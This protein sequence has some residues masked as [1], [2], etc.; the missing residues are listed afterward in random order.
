M[1]EEIKTSEEL[2]KEIENGE[3]KKEQPTKNVV[4]EVKTMDTNESGVLV[5]RNVDEAYRYAGMILK[6]K[7]APLSFD[8]TEKILVAM[9]TAKELDLPPLTSLKS[10]YVIANVVHLFGDLPLALCRRSKLM[11]YIEEIQYDQDGNDLNDVSGECYKAVCKVK[12]IGEKEIV[13]SITWPEVVKAGLDKNKF[14]VKDTYAKFRRRMMQ[15][16]MRTWALKDAFGDVLNG[17]SIF[18]Y[19]AVS[20]DEKEIRQVDAL[21]ARLNITKPEV[22][23]ET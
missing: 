15:M 20:S 21:N 22:E 11:E 10:M 6:S 13:R 8:T 12:R 2:K 4:A 7:L 1:S 5:P 17:I 14:G 16:R 3:T 19:D 18:E 9:Q 23:N